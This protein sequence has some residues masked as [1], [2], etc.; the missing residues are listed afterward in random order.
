LPIAAEAELTNQPDWTGSETPLI[1]EFNLKITGW[2]SNAGKRVLIPAGVFTAAEKH[3]FEQANR[4]HPIYFEYPYE[5]WDDVIIELPS[6]WQV[7]NV[8]PAQ[9]NDAHV[10]AY[11]LKAEGGKE[12]LHL[13]RKLKVNFLILDA[14]YYSALRSF[15]ETVRTGDEQQIV[16]QAAAAKEN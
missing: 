13:T 11:N 3:I 12:T 15:F 10:V 1:A 9:D 2:A 14:K 6:A 8:P 16:L 7:G 5:K 4:V